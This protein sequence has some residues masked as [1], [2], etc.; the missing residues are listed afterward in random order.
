MDTKAAANTTTATPPTG[1]GTVQPPLEQALVKLETQNPFTPIVWNQER[2]DLVKKT[3]CPKGIT[4]DELAVFLLQCKR[5][6]LDPLI[7]EA[8]C[9]PR[10]QNIAPKGQPEN[11]I[12]KNEFQPAEAGM[13]ARADRFPDYR[14]IKCAAVYENDVFEIDS[15]AGTVVHKFSPNKDR[16]RL[17]GAWARCFRADRHTPVEWCPLSEF[18]QQTSM[19]GKAETM[20]VKCARA[21]A[22]RRAYPNTFGGLYIE[23]EY[24][25]DEVDVT[26]AGP[27]G[28]NGTTTA[29]PGQTRSQA[30]TEKAKAAAEAAKGGAAAASP[31]TSSTSKPPGQQTIDAPKSSPPKAAAAKKPREGELTM[32]PSKGKLPAELSAD[33]LTTAIST[34][35]TNLKKDPVAK[36]AGRAQHELDG[37]QA[38]QKK[39]LAA[40]EA[41]AANG[42]REPGSDDGDDAPF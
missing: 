6:E 39:R 5:T 22:W 23:E 37:L 10:R 14:G 27:S 15:E 41:S 12:T 18:M 33:E 31:A 3:I 38:E 9:I 16:G 2:V 28:G 29:Q 21:A 24:A 30:V 35:E 1:G 11:W 32:G 25:R 7:K 34:H 17:K 19:W 13:A 4:D 40:A 36:W 26:P 20:I 8:F 42:D